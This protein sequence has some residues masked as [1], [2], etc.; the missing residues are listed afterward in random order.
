MHLEACSRDQSAAPLAL[1]LWAAAHICDLKLMMSSGQS[2]AKLAAQMK[3][4]CLQ[5]NL[6]LVLMHW[7]QDALHC[8]QGHHCLKHALVTAS[9]LAADCDPPV[10]QGCCHFA[11]A[12]CWTGHLADTALSLTVS[13]LGLSG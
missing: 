6:A 11:L 4:Q 12:L 2:Q 1:M 13:Q 3:H 7:L 10:H 5:L 8:W 9:S